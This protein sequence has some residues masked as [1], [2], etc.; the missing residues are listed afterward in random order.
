MDWGA[1]ALWWHP[2]V[3]VVKEKTPP[4]SPTYFAS[5][6]TY[7]TYFNSNADPWIVYKTNEEKTDHYLDSL[8]PKYALYEN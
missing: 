1:D 8:Q 4:G 5:S 7:L 3:Q 2:I 6:K